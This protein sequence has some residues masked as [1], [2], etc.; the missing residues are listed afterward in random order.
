MLR[1]LEP[2]AL[3]TVQDDGRPGAA[4]LGVPLSGAC[5]RLVDGRRQPAPR[6]R[7]RRG[8]PRDDAPRGATF[9]VT[10]SGVIAIAG[11]DMEARSSRRG[12][13]ARD[14]RRATSPGRTVASLRGGRAR[15]CGP[16]SRCPAASTSSRSWVPDRPASPAG[17]VGWTGVRS[18][19]GDRL[20][21]SRPIRRRR[22]PDRRWPAGGFDPTD[23]EAPVRH[24][25]RARRA[26]RPPRRV[27]GLS[28]ADGASRPSATGPASRL[29]GE[30][31]PMSDAAAALVSSGRAARRHPDAGVGRADRPLGRCTDGRR[32]PG[33]GRRRPRGSGHRRPAAAGARG[34]ACAPGRCGRMPVRR[35]AHGSRRGSIGIG[36]GHRAGRSRTDSRSPAPDLP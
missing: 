20:A 34:Y 15:R 13:T 14:R 12:A 26:G 5:D 9:E 31:L 11:A 8:R 30:P 27:R 28:D 2:G 18:A 10:A 7:R 21:A 32:L 24:R 16:T 33:A 3:S 19:T 22:E 36:G 25:G 23:P 6:Q 17:S 29:E 35:S 1:V 4:H